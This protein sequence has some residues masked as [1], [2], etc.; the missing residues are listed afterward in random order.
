MNVSRLLGLMFAGL[1]TAGVATAQT[2]AATPAPKPPSPT[3]LTLDLGFVNVD[4]NTR[5]TTLSF[6]DNLSYKARRWEFRELGAVV[7][8]RTN[9]TLTAEQYRVDGRIDHRLVAVLHFFVGGTY[10]RNRFAGIARRLEEYAG[11]AIRL[12]DIPSDLWTFDVGSSLNQQRSTT[13]TRLN[14]KAVRTAMLYRHNFN[15]ASYF[16][17]A[18]ETLPDLDDSKDLRVNGESSLVARLAGRAALKVSYVVRFDNVPEPGPPPFK[19]VD[20]MLATAL[21]ISF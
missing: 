2:P 14:F 13:R 4:G 15:Q 19:K 1:I 21:Q 7:Y 3:K 12:I 11:F 9:D 16:Q 5:V 10:E 20:R 18:V 17:L 6:A 8:G